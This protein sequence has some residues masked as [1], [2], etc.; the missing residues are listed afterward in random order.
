VR[1]DPR[2]AD[3]L[4]DLLLSLRVMR[5]EPRWR[6][7]LERLAETGRVCLL[8]A[9][10]AEIWCA[11]ERRSE[12]EL[13]LPD[14]RIAPAP[15]PRSE[16][17]VGTPL[18]RE[19][20]AAEALR[21]HL[22]CSGPITASRLA[23]RTLLPLSLVEIALARLEAEGFVL[24]GHFEGEEGAGQGEQFCARRLLARIHA[25][26]RDRLRREIEPASARDFLRFLMRW[27]HVAP[28]T[29]R[30]GRRGVLAAIQQ[31]QGFELGAG[32]WEES[33]LPSR[34]EEYRS[35]WLD[36][37]CL[38]GEVVWGRLSVRPAEP[39][40][41]A[42]RGGAVPS[43]ATP[44]S[45]LLRG[46]LPW[47]LAATR[48]ELSPAE[49]GPG[50]ALDILECLR[51]RGALFH[52]DLVSATGRLPVEIEEGLWDLVARGL[53][54]A[55]GFQ[56]VRSLLGARER[57]ARSAARTRRG[58]RGG[59]RDRASASGRWAL[60]PLEGCAQD[61]DELAE[62]VAEQLLARWGV[63]FR[64]LLAR[65]TLA[66]PWRELLWAFRR[67]EARGAI[68][69]G[70]FVSG[71]AGEQY[72]LP[73]AVDALRQTR[74]AKPDGQLVHLSATDPLNLVGILT[75]GSRIPALR[76]NRLC[77]RDGLPATQTCGS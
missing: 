60:L 65:E 32:A 34:V 49:P 11:T 50:A 70:R 77:L 64:E 18:D 23:E 38:S 57:W 27:Q 67:M 21:G 1:S 4:H 6:E 22:E 71:F 12:A 37:L 44:V 63:A 30:E 62:L 73:G 15:A 47:L 42:G 33:L 45:L 7:Q 8:W 31:L 13:L 69:G 9:G 74:R 2:D 26:T 51:S 29:R 3:E 53:V 46:D 16:L 41:P 36:S 66:L 59:R 39:D 10:E 75:P 68:R 5:A 14:A 20:A 48:G 55:D 72:A 43:R 24:R 25:Y 19:A 35:E 76:T 28:G 17:G 54:S 58:R 56:A 52:A 61:P 40:A